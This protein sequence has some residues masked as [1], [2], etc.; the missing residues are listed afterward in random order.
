MMWAQWEQG[1]IGRG[2][3]GTER[4]GDGGTMGADHIGTE[5]DEDGDAMNSVEKWRSITNYYYHY[6]Y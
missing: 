6:Y 2:H 4:D 1:K 5:K 3:N